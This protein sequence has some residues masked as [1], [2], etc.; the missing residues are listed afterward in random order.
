MHVKTK[1]HDAVKMLGELGSI[2]LSVNANL[3]HLVTAANLT[4]DNTGTIFRQTG[5][6]TGHLEKM[7][8][9]L[10]NMELGLITL[11]HRMGEIA[12]TMTRQQKMMEKLYGI[13]NTKP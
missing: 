6:A 4:K 3:S 1:D 9:R 8:K 10:T 2:L 5:K 11:S 13:E 12:E 7:E